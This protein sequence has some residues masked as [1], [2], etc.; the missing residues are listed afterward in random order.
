MPIAYQS[1][2]YILPVCAT[3]AKPVRG[4]KPLSQSQQMWYEN[5]IDA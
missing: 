5:L 3:M 1:A 2:L 4:S